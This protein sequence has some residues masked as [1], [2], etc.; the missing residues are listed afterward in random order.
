MR[1]VYKMVGMGNNVYGRARYADSLMNQTNTMGGVKK[2]G[3]PST[4]GIDSSVSGVYRKRI[5]CLCPTA[6][7][8]VNSVRACSHIGRPAGVGGSRC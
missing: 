3:L 4:V 8:M 2:Q 5:G 6:Y 1:I 7:A